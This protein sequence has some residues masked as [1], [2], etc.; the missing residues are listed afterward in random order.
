MKATLLLTTPYFLL[1]LLFPPPGDWCVPSKRRKIA[2]RRRCSEG[3]L[4][5]PLW[6][7]ENSR[8][9]FLPFLFLPFPVTRY[10][11]SAFQNTAIYIYICICWVHDVL[12][13]ISIL[14]R[15]PSFPLLSFADDNKPT[16]LL[17]RAPNSG[18]VEKKN[19]KKKSL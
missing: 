8:F 12:P 19:K 13:V 6:V 7:E 10:G 1:F 17:T 3:E 9:P 4:K 2:R 5:V 15:F 14:S 18:N 11:V 16:G